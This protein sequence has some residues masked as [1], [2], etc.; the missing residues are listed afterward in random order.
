M[1]CKKILTLLIAFTI[2][3]GSAVLVGCDK[4]NDT[5]KNTKIESKV[6]K[7]KSNG[8]FEN[9]MNK[10]M[11]SYEVN[12]N[13]I[14]LKS[15]GE[16]NKEIS[17]EDAE[18]HK[19]MWER[20]KQIIPKS[21]LNRI[22]RYEVITDGPDNILAFVNADENNKIWTLSIDIKD[23]FD[24]NGKL[25]GKALDETIV[26]EFG[27]IL[28]LNHEQ[29]VPEYDEASPTYVTNEGTTNKDA[30]L[31]LF[32][33][34]FWNGIHDELKR[35]NDE[36]YDGNVPEEPET[37]LDFYEKYKDQ[38][39]SDY[40]ATNPEEDIAESFRTFV[41]ENKPQ[42]KTIAEKKMLFF[43]DFPELVKIRKEIRGNLNLN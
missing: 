21:Y 7:D 39:V 27:H 19:I 35:A 22:K 3:S 17:K 34:K 8:Q 24:E 37:N 31:N 18:K 38:F 20:A 41:T 29:V 43:Y 33:K 32:Y 6:K 42:G 5:A 13:N 11:A 30:Y 16:N 26:H 4:N 23:A 15:I 14:Q 36:K 9:E 25:I 10:L 1:K 2:V 40:A 28:T 12:S